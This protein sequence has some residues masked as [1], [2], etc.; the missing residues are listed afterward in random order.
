[1]EVIYIGLILILLVFISLVFLKGNASL[2]KDVASLKSE[3]EQLKIDLAKAEER[4]G[5]VWQEKENTVYVLRQELQ[6]LQSELHQERQNLAAVNISY[7]S[8]RIYI[9]TQ[10]E[11]IAEQKDEI[12]KLHIKLSKDFELLANRIL[13]EKTQ[14]FTEVNRFN[15]DL[16]LNPLKENIRS[17][18]EKV[19]KA[20]SAESAER[21][22][23]KGE[24]IKLIELNKQISDEA[25]NLT[26]ALKADS[27]KQGNWGEV[28]LD[29][30]LEASG[31][32]AGESYSKQ[33]SFTDES[34]NRLQPDVVINLPDDKH[35]IIDSKVSLIA[36]NRLVNC[37]TDSERLSYLN[38]H[39]T[40][41]KN[42]IKNLCSKN[43]CDLYAVNSPDFVLL[44]IPIES[45]FAIAVQHDIEL[46]EFAWNKR[47][48]IVTPSTLLATLKTISSVW[49]QEKQTRNAIDIAT[50]AGALYDKFVSFLSD[51]KRVGESLDK[52]R[53]A[54]GEAFN[55]L[56]SG[57]GNIVGKIEALKKLGAKASKQIDS[58]FIVEE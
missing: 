29:R 42:H 25:N 46:F 15:L 43:Y 41:I 12:E 49:K 11:K 27:K 22:V 35:L 52:A 56:S 50:R 47:V 44:F 24:I 34:G 30:I 53:D 2:K 7:E 48:V 3:N 57:N 20:Y 9:K 54:Y 51:L 8:T 23:L 58:R 13:E 16:L 18:E 39:I 32:I 14:K 31:L 26:K 6:K 10:Q 21:N 33:A 1:M 36:Y 45:S 55:K 5:N 4:F 28:V 37:D 19:E 17:F 40:S 38:D